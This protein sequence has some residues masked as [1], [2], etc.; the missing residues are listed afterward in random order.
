ME[1]SPS[2]PTALLRR[3]HA[4]LLTGSAVVLLVLA[5][6]VEHWPANGLEAYDARS[7]PELIHGVDKVTRRNAAFLQMGLLKMSHEFCEPE[8]LAA[9]APAAVQLFGQECPKPPA[10][11][12]EQ[13]LPPSTALLPP[14]GSIPP[15]ITLVSLVC[16]SE[17]L[18]GEEDGIVTNPLETG[19]EWERPAWVSARLDSEVLVESP[20]GLRIHGG[21]TRMT[22]Q[23]GFRLV[24][25]NDHGGKPAAPEGLFFGKD[26]PASSHF[27][28]TNAWHPS[29]FKGAVA[30]EIAGLLGC[31]VSKCV[32]VLVQI[33]G[34]AIKAPFFIYQHQSAEFVRK[35][36]GVEDIDFVRLKAREPNENESYIEWRKWIRRER[37]PISMEEEGARFDLAELSA[38]VVAMT[39]TATSDNNQGGYFKD[40]K[41]P[42]AKWRTLVWDMDQ[43]FNDTAH[44]HH[45]R[46]VNFRD[47]PFEALIGDRARLFFRLIEGSAEYREWFR[48]Y[49]RQQL[50]TNLTQEKVM[51]IVDRYTA[52]AKL[53]P[54]TAPG[55]ME[56]LQH[57]REFLTERQ[58]TYLQ[59]VEQRLGEAEKFHDTR[60]GFFAENAGE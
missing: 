52:I 19:P 48:T 47:Q 58:N 34:T 44:V 14:V 15:G 2:H 17:H 46:R 6:G 23:K 40:R 32:P 18:F 39:F 25:S 11:L 35:R 57:S 42:N 5:L 4:F 60:L 38:W 28:L 16:R 36:F 49:V 50:R 41:D 26:S 30:T 7:R 43:A 9:H 1:N 37:F 10:H 3:R 45:G 24:F 53:Q 31:H 12:L 21:F 54:H 59:L 22:P 55:L 51:A 56:S 13:D 8:M 29:R 27:V 33:N 20:I